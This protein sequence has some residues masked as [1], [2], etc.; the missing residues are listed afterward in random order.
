MSAAG[1]PSARRLRFLL[2]AFFFGYFGCLGLFLPYW[3]L[4]LQSLGLGAAAIGAMMATN[5]LVRIGGPLAWGWYMDRTR[6]RTRPIA[7]AMLLGM[8][9]LAL[10]PW[11]DGLAW[12]LLAQALYALFWA[13][14]NPAFDV[15]TIAHAANI[16]R[17]YSQIRLWGSVGF[18]V[19][20]VAGGWLTDRIG[21]VV[22]PAVMLLGMAGLSLVAFATPDAEGGSGE[23][24]AAEPFRLA[25]RRPS[26]M[27]LLLVCFLSQASF[28]PY[29]TFFSIH[30]QR[31]GYSGTSIGALWALGVFAEIAVFVYAGRL[32]ERLGVRLIL[33]WA[34]AS[35]AVRW[36]LV[37][38][39][40][41]QPLILAGS[42]LL[43]LSSFGLYQAATVQYVQSRF[44]RAGQGRAQ[45]L[46]TSSGF[47]L[48]GALGAL[49]S[50]AIWSRWPGA[51]I[52]AL[53]GVSAAAG[54]AV[55][56]TAF[57]R[58]PRRPRPP[59]R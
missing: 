46:V 32:I 26:F 25:W 54:M 52:F 51:P 21:L 48:G 50:G 6:R 30:L 55:L 59:A 38:A 14:G 18:I 44:E 47:G 4:Y 28:A 9:P 35:T 13:A 53:A 7:A 57:E 11:L 3:P 34:L 22:V 41:G 5:N 56:W 33:L 19:T 27:V 8:V 16:R 10:I 42:Q 15:V 43:H 36:W 23:G 45:A 49:L 40:A 29:Y 31:L 1:P 12:L 37:A 39:F 24:A 2:G 58:T 20:V 17:H